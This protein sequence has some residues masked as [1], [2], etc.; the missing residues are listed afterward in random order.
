MED[1]D[2]KTQVEFLNTKLRHLENDYN[3][4]KEENETT[5]SKYLEILL[6]IKEKNKELKQEITERK[7][8]E[9]ILRES[10]L[11]YSTLVEQAKEGVVIIQ[12]RV[13]KYANRAMEEISGYTIKEK[14]NTF[15][16]DLFIPEYRK[17]ALQRY[18]KLLA[19]K[20][21]S[22]MCEAKI[23]RKDG[24][25]R[26]VEISSSAIQYKGKPADMAVLRDITERKQ[27]E[28]MLVQSEKMAS[29]GVL[30]AGVAHE[31]NN[32]IGY[33]YSNLK[34]LQKYWDK[35]KNFIDSTSELIVENSKDK[36]DKT[37]KLT[38]DFR[39][40]REKLNIDYFIK[41]MKSAIDES[42]E[43]AEKVRKIVLDLRDFSREEKFNIKLED[44]N[45]GIEKTLNVIWN[46]LKYKAEVVK[47]LDK[48]PPVE[49]DIQRLS[50][51]FMNLLINA[52]QA[53]EK[54]GT[55]KIRTFN[56]NN[57]VVVQISDT[58]TGIPKENIKRLFDAFFTTKEAGKGTGLGL[59]ISYKI[60]QEH[61]GTIDVESEV[62]KGTVFTIKLP[63][64][65]NKKNI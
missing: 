57:N 14:L 32:P 34:T 28:Q 8:F 2:S 21:I 11:K 6:E 35:L 63:V 19:G 7:R 44:I 43:G 46:E 52:A 3:L 30:A 49:C 61:N 58:G 40:L 25:I 27:M 23:Q 24:V 39:N 10:E 60:I 37:N 18:E 54:R 31:I 38:E 65:R 20:E 41:D 42:L 45:N 5:T 1:K 29:I 9:G 16:P 12:D 64:K 22:S 17:V 48:I 15:F 47:E 56:E 59:S 50:Q 62:G 36:L 53:I 55:I 4:M 33:V 26:D 13:I 51:V